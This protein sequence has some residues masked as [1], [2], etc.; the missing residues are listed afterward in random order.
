M[1]KTLGG[2]R[3]LV[4]A[5]R[6]CE[7]TSGIAHGIRHN[8]EGCPASIDNSDVVWNGARSGNLHAGLRRTSG[9]SGRG[10]AHS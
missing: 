7:A 9:R 6:R 5:S 1:N 2:A 10:L 8:P 4:D 3:F